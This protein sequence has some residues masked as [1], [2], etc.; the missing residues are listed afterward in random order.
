MELPQA[1]TST[2][3]KGPVKVMTEKQTKHTNL[4]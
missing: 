1:N 4:R 3:G 2:F